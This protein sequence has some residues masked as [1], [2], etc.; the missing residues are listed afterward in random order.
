MERGGAGDDDDAGSDTRQS[1][2][3]SQFDDEP[4]THHGT[5][6]DANVDSQITTIDGGTSQSS[7]EG[8]VSGVGRPA[9]DFN[10]VFRTS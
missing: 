6:I 9:L 7:D 10:T 4:G 1:T 5:Q 2:S 8:D 3:S